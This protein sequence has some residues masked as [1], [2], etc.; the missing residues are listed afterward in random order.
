MFKISLSPGH[1]FDTPGKRTPDGMREWEF[2][3]A[4]VTKMVELFSH[5]KDVK[6]KRLDDPTGK[7]DVPLKERAQ[8]SDSFDADFHLDVHANAFG[9]TWNDANGIETFSYHLQGT[10]FEIAKKLQKAL[11]DA[12]GLKNRGVKDGEHLYM[13]NHPKAPACLVECGFMTNKADAALLKSDA[14]RVKIADTLVKAIAS[15]FNLVKEVP[16]PVKP[17]PAPADGKLY[18]VQVGAFSKKENAE[19]LLKELAAKGY[20]GVVTYE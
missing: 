1:G 3:S 10:G 6:V 12:T 7:R 16:T 17:T 11:V 5:Y 8:G 2:N 19:S 13:V 15:H 4:V 14:Y 9:E 18:K 20:K